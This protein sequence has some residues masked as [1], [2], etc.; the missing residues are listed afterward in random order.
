METELTASW[1]QRRYPLH[2]L[3]ICDRRPL[4]PINQLSQNEL[5]GPGSYSVDHK[6]RDTKI[7]STK[8]LGAICSKDKRAFAFGKVLV[9][10]APGTYEAAGGAFSTAPSRLGETST[11][12]FKPPQQRSVTVAEDPMPGPGQYK[13]RREFDAS[14]PKVWLK[15]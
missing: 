2:A 15:I 7:Y 4:I 12:A 1:R 8:G 10:P 5:P 9:T 14:A 6:L 13:T 3:V 11:S